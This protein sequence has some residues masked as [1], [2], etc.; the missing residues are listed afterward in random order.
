MQLKKVEFQKDLF[1][2]KNISYGFCI[3]PTYLIIPLIIGIVINV[4][5]QFSKYQLSDLRAGRLIF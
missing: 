1:I 5:F 2:S 3:P 4:F